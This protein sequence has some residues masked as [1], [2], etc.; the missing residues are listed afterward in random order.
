MTTILQLFIVLGC[1][2][3]VHEFGHFAAAKICGVRVQ[4]F[5]L[6]FGKRLIG[7]RHGDTDYRIN[8]LPLGGYVK[9]AGEV[10]GEQ[11]SDDPG[12]INNHP[13]WQRIFI[14]IAGP[15]SN[16]LFAFTLMGAA[17]MLHD[18]VNQYESGP[19]TTDY[20]SPTTAAAKTGLRSGDTIVRFDTLENPTWIDIFN[21]APLDINRTVPFSFVRD[22]K[23][24]DTTFFLPFAGAPDKFNAESTLETGL[25]PQ[26]QDT[27]LRI[28]SIDRNSASARAG[29]LPGDQIVRVDGIAI[30]SIPALFWYLQDQRGKP[31]QLQV[32]RDGRELSLTASP[33][34]GDAGDESTGYHLGFTAAP[35]PVKLQ[36]LSLA[37]SLAASWQFNTKNSQLVFNV[38]KSMLVRHATVRNLSGPIGIGQVVHHAAAAP[39]WMPLIATMATIS[40]NLG[41]FNLM[42]FPIL[43]GGMIFLLLVEGTFRRDVPVELKKH[44]YQAAFV[45][46]LLFAV[47]V[48][49]NDITKLPFFIKLS[50]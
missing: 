7:F 8:L 44:A 50:S 6:G 19:A 13:R 14:A 31:A 39:G 28:A 36:R 21:Q 38:L 17:F 5:A 25:V 11:A 23:R 9:M 12:D 26:M 35:A 2:V 33:E 18:Q 29:L 48:I 16:F 45:C 47:I 3:L 43:D 10:P 15:I 4:A 20:V 40:I 24:V 42:P 27:P 41:I 46:I 32:L 49:F 37:S 30:R 1:M 22:G 34:F